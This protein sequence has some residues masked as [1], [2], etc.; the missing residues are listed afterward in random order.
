MWDQPINQHNTELWERLPDSSLAGIHDAFQD[1]TRRL[2]ISL[3]YCVY[4]RDRA[5]LQQ[6]M[7]YVKL[8]KDGQRKIKDRQ[9]ANLSSSMALQSVIVQ[10][11][12]Q[13]VLT[14]QT[15]VRFPVTENVTTRSTAKIWP[16]E[17]FLCQNTFCLIS[18]PD[19]HG[20]DS[21]ESTLLT[22]LLTNNDIF[23]CCNQTC[24]RLRG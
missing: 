18:F 5:A 8:A 15:G 16:I 6:E 4:P 19:S 21:Q 17:R 7:K 23:S 2:Y 14:L 10:R 22:I 9:P 24:T 1:E 20:Q 12:G 13:Q 3:S 11:L